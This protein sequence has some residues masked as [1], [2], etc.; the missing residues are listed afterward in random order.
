MG[1]RQSAV[2]AGRGKVTGWL[3]FRRRGHRHVRAPWPGPRPGPAGR[4]AG[5]PARGARAGP[6]AGGYGSAALFLISLASHPIPGGR[7]RAA[8][9]WWPG[10]S[11]NGTNSGCALARVPPGAVR[12]AGCRPPA[13]H[14]D[15]LPCRHLLACGQPAEDVQHGSQPGVRTSQAVL[16]PAQGLHLW[17]VEAHHHHIR[18]WGMSSVGPGC[19]RRV[20]TVRGGWCRWEAETVS[21]GLRSGRCGSVADAA[22]RARTT[23][24]DRVPAGRLAPARRVRASR[25]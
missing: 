6:S 20:K 9:P 4:A 8:R 16:N 2:P 19:M 10:S 5:P 7:W 15:V 3:Y 25:R 23:R 14:P 13:P 22:V 11:G 18:G 17:F 12:T 21:R 1:F 24:R